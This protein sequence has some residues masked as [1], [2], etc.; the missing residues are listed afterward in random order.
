MHCRM[1]SGLP[2]LYPLD[3]SSSSPTVITK[4]SLAHCQRSLEGFLVENNY[5]RST[6]DFWREGTIRPSSFYTSLH[7]W[8]ADFP[9]RYSFRGMTPDLQNQSL[10]GIGPRI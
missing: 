6:C 4:D 1:S 5:F 2:G 8:E 9:P 7:L 3:P 10:W